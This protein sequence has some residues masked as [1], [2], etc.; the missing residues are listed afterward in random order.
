MR[1]HESKKLELRGRGRNDLLLAHR[2]EF[3]RMRGA[4]VGSVFSSLF[5]SVIPIVKSAYRVGEN[6]IKTPLGQK[7]AKTVK[8][9]AV[10]AGINVVR[11]ALRGENIF[12]ST[13]REVKS[14]KNSVLG[15]LLGLGHKQSFKSRHIQDNYGKKKQQTR[16]RRE[17]FKIRKR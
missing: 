1:V 11:D 15:E 13:K 12:K 7:I 6:A 2:H 3:E 5:S 14:A 4:G 8:K 9:Q 16:D 17:I 10:K